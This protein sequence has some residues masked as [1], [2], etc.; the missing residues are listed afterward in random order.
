MALRSIAFCACLVAVGVITS[1][2]DDPELFPP[3][4]SIQNAVDHYVQKKLDATGVTS[5]APAAPESLLRR[6]TLDI[7]GRIPTQAEVV[8]YLGLPVERRQEMLVDRLLAMCDADFHT[9]NEFDSL[10]LGN[11]PF[12]DEFRKYVL[13][14]ARQ[15]RSWD[16]MFRDMLEARYNDG[17]LKG[18]SQF[19]KTR[20]RQLDDMT[21][22][23]AILFFGVNVSC[24]K[25]HDHPLVEDWKQDNFYGMQAFF[26]RTYQTR[27][28]VVAE[29]FFDTVKFRTT[30]GVEKEAAYMFLTGDSIFNGTPSYTDEERKSLEEKIRN[31]EQKDNSEIPVP[32]FS[33]R[34]R[35]IEVALLEKNDTFFARNLANRIWA[36][37][38]GEGLVSPLDQMHSGNPPSHPELLS[39]LANDIKQ[40]GYYVDRLVRGIAL[41]RTYAQSSEWVSADERPAPTLFAV[42]QPRP[43]TP[44][45]LA[46]SL[47]IAARNPE[48]WPAVDAN[49]AWEKE[50]ESI[51]SQANGW[52]REFEQPGSNFQV[53]VDE[54]LFFNNN[55]R[56]QDDLLRDSGDSLIGYLKKTESDSSDKNVKEVANQLW[57]TVL[58]RSPSDEESSAAVAW[59]KRNEVNRVESIRQL[60]WALLAGPEFRFNH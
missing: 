43:L 49:A 7:A 53:A 3:T 14:A 58:S 5:A 50:R 30:D 31:A 4:E 59:L 38:M 56:V 35:L 8:W 44:R 2:A 13:W 21:N 34:Q 19:L 28:N 25:C 39:W 9:A 24:A 45:Q 16:Q 57:L 52:V 54:A 40:N 11:K 17:P 22:D 51:E 41:S 6:T 46:A 55:S 48:K 20:I 10:L 32:E 27:K 37:M 29:K 36:R 60:A 47:R 18:A 42:S 26:T 15:N 23:T 12:D 1:A 33:P